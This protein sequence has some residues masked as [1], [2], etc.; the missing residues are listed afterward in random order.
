MDSSIFDRLKRTVTAEVLPPFGEKR[1]QL[2][3]FFRNLPQGGIG[4]HLTV[5]ENIESIKLHG[6]DLDFVKG[7]GNGCIFYVFLDPTLDPILSQSNNLDGRVITYHRLVSSLETLTQHVKTHKGNNGAAVVVFTHPLTYATSNE[8]ENPH[9]LGILD[10]YVQVNINKKKYIVRTGFKSPRLRYDL[11]WAYAKQIPRSEILLN[12]IY[13]I[14][15]LESSSSFA[16]RVVDSM[17]NA[18]F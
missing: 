9:E 3:D 7:K 15:E 11:P 14:T 5:P 13:Q 2:N 8:L 17:L 18:K 6:L 4:L 16:K 1:R 12:Q 10:N